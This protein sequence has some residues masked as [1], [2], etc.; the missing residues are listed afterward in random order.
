M[1]G[2]EYRIQQLVQRI[3][4]VFPQDPVPRPQELISHECEECFALR[5]DFSGYRWVE[6]PR[7]VLEIHY[8]DLSLF[9]P[10]AYHYYLPSYLSYSLQRV[11]PTNEEWVSEIPPSLNASEYQPILDFTIY[12]LYSSEKVSWADRYEAYF[13]STQVEVVRKWL[14]LVLE[15]SNHFDADEEVARNALE[16]YWV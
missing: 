15:N 1:I 4:Q 7:K 5:D 10:V 9:T 16:Q 6:V 14:S 3:E 11:P 8:D 13:I 2:L 12:S